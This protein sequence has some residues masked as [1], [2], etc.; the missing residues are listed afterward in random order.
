MIPK[1]LDIAWKRRGPLLAFVGSVAVVSIGVAL[2][3]PPWYRA[4]ATILPPQDS[5]DA[6]SSITSLLE[7]SALS[8]VGLTTNAT[9]SDVFKEILE[10]RT[11]NAFLVERFDLSRRYR[12]VGMERTLKELGHHESVIVKSS[13]VL[14]LQVEDHEPKTSAAMANALIEELDRFN[15]ETYNTRAKRTRIFLE[16]RIADTEVH[17]RESERLLTEYERRHGVVAEEQSSSAK[18]VSDALSR[19]M[20]L[21]IQHA[22]ISSYSRPDNP[23][24]REVDASL[25]AVDQE[26]AKL[27]PVK[28]EG[29]RLAMDASIQRKVF[30]LLTGQYEEA[31]VQEQRDTPTLTVLDAAAVPEMRS[32]PRR[33]IIVLV[34]VLIS[35]ALGIGWVVYVERRVYPA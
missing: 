1:I 5:G 10:S 20:S 33:G 32:R 8:R 7:S 19:K 6:T 15:R 27:P 35:A 34:S 21:E 4:Q 14:I 2:L 9:P 26:L 23:D 22:Y 16:G 30:T 3:L 13:G 11:L 17:M 24:L 31:R 12:R 29:A 28:Q 25:A 18:P